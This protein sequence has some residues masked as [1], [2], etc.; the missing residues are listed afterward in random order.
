MKKY[1]V[2]SGS[3][4]PVIKIG[5]ELDLEEVT[6]PDLKKFDIIVFREGD[7]Y[8]CHY[9]WHIN[10]HIDAGMITT[11]NL[12]GYKFDHPFHFNEVIGRV[13][14]YQLPLWIRLKLIFWVR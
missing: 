14:N 3:M 8:T 4:E 12:D 13:K 11:R 2:A 7:K 1:R 5:A 9:I 6:L 10:Q